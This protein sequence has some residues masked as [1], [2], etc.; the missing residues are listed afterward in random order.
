[1]TNENFSK[2]IADIT[3]MTKRMSALNIPTIRNLAPTLDAMKRL[4]ESMSYKK[5]L[6]ALNNV[7]KLDIPKITPALSSLIEAQ[8]RNAKLLKNIQLNP[9]L[10]SMVER[11]NDQNKSIEA[12]ST[13][14]ID[15]QRAKH[16]REITQ[17]D[18]LVKT[19]ETLQSLQETMIQSLSLQQEIQASIIQATMDLVQATNN[20]PIKAWVIISFAGS[21]FAALASAGIL[22]LF[23]K[24]DPFIISF[25]QSLFL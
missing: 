13:A 7:P 18:A 24:F 11:Q 1:M 23:S 15:I 19:A 20:P 10:S 25:L 3:K 2:Q 16:Q 4:E 21:F 22:Y 9:V 8:E 17:T 14:L 6:S 5:T 12:A